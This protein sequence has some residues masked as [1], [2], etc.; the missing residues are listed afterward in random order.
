MYQQLHSLPQA[1]QIEL[2]TRHLVSI[3]S[4]NG[5]T[6]EIDLAD[7]LVKILRSFP[8]FQQHPAWVWTQ[9]LPHDQLGRK[10][11]FALLKKPDCRQTIIYHSHFDTVGIQ[12]FGALEASAFDP[13]AL[14]AYFATYQADHEVQA[15]AQSGDW[16][17][18]RGALDMKSGDAVNLVNLLYYSEHPA[19]LGGN[20]LFMGN[21]VEENDHSGVITGLSELHRLQVEQ[22]LK[23]V[24]AIN[25]DF[26]SPK[27]AGDKNKYVYYG[28]AG[29]MLTCC[30]IKGIET[31]V[32][33]TYSGIDST[34]IASQINL[35]LNNNPQFV[36]QIPNEEVLPSSCLQLRDQKDFYNVQTAKVTEMY[37]NTFTYQRPA[38]DTLELFRDAIEEACRQL[39]KKLT[40]RQQKFFSTLG[41]PAVAEHKQLFVYTFAEYLAYL[42]TKGLNTAAL[43]AEFSQQADQFDRRQVGFKLI[44]FLDQHLNDNQAKVVLFIEPPFCPHNS[45]KKTTVVY[46]QLV[47]V[48]K[49]SQN[50]TEIELKEFFPYLSDSSY[51]AI[52]ETSKELSRL[53]ANFP[54]AEQIYPLPFDQMREL[55]IPAV[56]IGVYG[57][58]A[59]TWKERVYKPYSFNALPCLIREFSQQ[60]WQAT[61][62]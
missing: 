28:A 30:Y 38:A 31:H 1:K 36:E 45:V 49:R 2:L 44:D 3:G 13:T 54:L 52:D 5:T 32:G 48:L 4:V 27:Y 41:M 21:C 12:D 34:L 59:H 17:F 56:D 19:E 55:A 26:N 62:E 42:K 22:N 24:T 15:D 29:K 9:S 8:V 61:K 57:K 23:Y 20:L 14:Q 60:I 37:F 58:G 53:Q 40:V 16:L 7:E 35:L 25:T 47:K 46:Q 11:V 6:G 39:L 43:V 33:N 10:N 50:Q 18:G 51:L